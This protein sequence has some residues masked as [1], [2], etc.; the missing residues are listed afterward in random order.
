MKS[1]KISEAQLMK[2][3]CDYYHCS[4]CHDRQY[5]ECDHNKHPKF[6]CPGSPIIN[7]LLKLGFEIWRP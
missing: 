5:P 7:I 2:V 1:C 3:V 4:D 6:H